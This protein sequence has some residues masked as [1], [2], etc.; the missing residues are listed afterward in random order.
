MKRR[1]ERH[2]EREIQLCVLLSPEQQRVKGICMGDQMG[3]RLS[4]D[5]PVCA[6]RNPTAASTQHWGVNTCKWVNIHRSGSAFGGAGESLGGAWETLWVWNHQEELE[7]KWKCETQ[8]SQL[9]E[10]LWPLDQS[11]ITS[12]LEGAVPCEAAAFSIQTLGALAWKKVL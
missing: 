7:D 2:K 11:L 4:W 1:R 3:Q 12:L 9:R 5:W 10:A 6:P 8:L